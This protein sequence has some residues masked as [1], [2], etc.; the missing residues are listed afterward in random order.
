MSKQ[1]MAL[2]RQTVRNEINAVPTYMFYKLK[3]K[4]EP[5]PD[6]KEEA[7]REWAGQDFAQGDTEHT[8]TSTAWKFAWESRLFPSVELSL[9]LEFL[10][11][12]AST[13][14]TVDTTA[15]RVMFRTISEIFAPDSPLVDNALALLPHTDKAGTTY[16][17]QFVGGRIKDGELDFKG[18]ADAMLKLNF[19]GG[20]WIGDPGQAEVAG[21]TFPAT[22]QFRAGNLRCFLGAGATLTG[23]VPNYTDIAEGSM[24]AFKPDDLTVKITP[25]VDDKYKMNGYEG[26][27]VTERTGSWELTVEGT[28][29]FED[30]SS[31]WSSYD[32]WVAQFADMAYVPF[33]LKLDSGEV[34]GAVDQTAQMYLYV[35]KM[36]LTTDMPDR[37]TDG[38]KTKIKVKLTSLIDPA[39]NV[40]AFA[41]LIY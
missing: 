3:G 32:A 28:V 12:Y 40:A 34:V 20:P 35:P 9:L 31:G 2:S 8:R 21:M 37:K 7:T 13:P 22:R 25:N 36:K 16:H 6:F 5:E 23:T 18:G 15:S 29:D 27:S 11:G 26:P 38:S 24:P 14:A 17:Q 30:P 4:L 39:I 33:M 1:Y 41:K 19:I 10:L